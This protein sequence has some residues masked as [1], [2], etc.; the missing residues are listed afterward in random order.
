M[1]SYLTTTR[2]LL[3]VPGDPTR[4]PQ[5]QEVS[6]PVQAES[7]SLSRVLFGEVRLGRSKPRQSTAS[8]TELAEDFFGSYSP[9]AS[10]D[11]RMIALVRSSA[12]I[13]LIHQKAPAAPVI[14][15]ESVN[16][17]PHRTEA[18]A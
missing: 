16:I 9:A 18:G 2:Q 10:P 1:L 14:N 6:R 4:P 11:D 7:A 13:L 17:A 15:A 5:S 3:Q 8:K 12:S